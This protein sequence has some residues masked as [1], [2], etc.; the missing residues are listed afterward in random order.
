MG[1]IGTARLAAFSSCS[2]LQMSLGYCS[3]Q[4]QIVACCFPQDLGAT[5]PVLHAADGSTVMVG[6]YVDTIGTVLLLKEQQGPAFNSKPNYSLMGHTEKQL[7]MT[8]AD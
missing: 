2:H 3:A 6:K 7:Q 8:Q 5:K 4:D 1:M